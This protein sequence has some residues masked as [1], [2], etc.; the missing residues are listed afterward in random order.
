[1]IVFGLSKEDLEKPT[2]DFVDEIKLTN[3]DGNEQLVTKGDKVK[4][5]KFDGRDGSEYR[6]KVIKIGINSCTIKDIGVWRCGWVTLYLTLDNGKEI[7]EYAHF[8]Q[9]A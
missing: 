4:L 1:M 2:I 6:E 8:F 3:D 5:K 7:Q 9:E